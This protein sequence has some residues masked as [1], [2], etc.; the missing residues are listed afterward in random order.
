M[1]EPRPL[2]FCMVTTF[3]PPFHF[4]GDSCVNL[5]TD[6]A[7]DRHSKMP[8]FKACAVAISRAGGP[9]DG[10]LLTTRPPDIAT[11]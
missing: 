9:D 7:L 5:L 6:P 4:G 3:Y 8:A 1:P 10:H 2:R 11:G